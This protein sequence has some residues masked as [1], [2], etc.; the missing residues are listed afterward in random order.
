[1]DLTVLELKQ[2]KKQL[3]TRRLRK[4]RLSKQHMTRA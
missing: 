2:I 4:L 3:E 1:M